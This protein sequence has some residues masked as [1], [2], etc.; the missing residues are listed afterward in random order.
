MLLITFPLWAYINAPKFAFR[1]DA[2]RGPI[3]EDKFMPCGLLQGLRRTKI[4]QKSCIPALETRSLG[5]EVSTNA[6]TLTGPSD[7]EQ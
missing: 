3:L 5:S 7:E 4:V 2:V 1:A 6:G